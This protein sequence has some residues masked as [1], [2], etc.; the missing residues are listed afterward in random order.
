MSQ[1]LLDL[2]NEAR[3]LQEVPRR[4]AH[5]KKFG[6]NHQVGGLRLGRQGGGNFL[7]IAAHVSH[8]GIELGQGDLHGFGMIV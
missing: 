4:V 3:L 7:Q 1:G 8:H 2:A 6:E 5:Q